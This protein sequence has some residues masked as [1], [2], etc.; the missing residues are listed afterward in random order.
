MDSLLLKMKRKGNCSQRQNPFLFSG[1]VL[2]FTAS[3]RNE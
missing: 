1:C 3:F 2:I